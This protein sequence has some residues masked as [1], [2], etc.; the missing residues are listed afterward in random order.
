MPGCI[1]HMGVVLQL[2]KDAKKNKGDMNV[3]WLDLKNAYGSIPHNLVE[4]AF[5]RHHVLK[6]ITELIVDYYN[7][8]QM[9]TVLGIPNQHGIH[10]K[11]E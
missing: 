6:K 8:F 5:K 9:R 3:L 4:E 7:D 10:W 11:K 2:L 1:E